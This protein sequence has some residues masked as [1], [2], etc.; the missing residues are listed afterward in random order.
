[1][2]VIDLGLILPR[3]GTLIYTD[4]VTMNYNIPDTQQLSGVHELFSV[5]SEESEEEKNGK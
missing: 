5:S 3:Q 4:N 1:M 2:A